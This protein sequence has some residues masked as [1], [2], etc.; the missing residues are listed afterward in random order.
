MKRIALF[1]AT[2]IAVLIILSIVL[3]IL[4]V[5]SLLQENNV[6]LDIQALLIFSAVFGMGGSFISLAMSKWSA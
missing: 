4:G 1:L 6:D 5:D 2:N 3:S